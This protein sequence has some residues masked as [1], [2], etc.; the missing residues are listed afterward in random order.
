MYIKIMFVFVKWQNRRRKKEEYL[1][2]LRNERK[3]IEEGGQKPANE[4]HNVIKKK[5]IETFYEKE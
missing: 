3:K 4:I 2:R 1:K 5:H